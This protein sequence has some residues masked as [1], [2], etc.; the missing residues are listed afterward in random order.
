MHGLGAVT[1]SPSPVAIV[2]N[3]REMLEVN[4]TTNASVLTWSLMYIS[5]N[6]M[7]EQVSDVIITS[8]AM[9]QPTRTINSSVVRFVRRSEL[10][11]TPLISSLLIDSVSLG[12]NGTR[13]T[14]RESFST[15]T[16]GATTMIYIIPGNK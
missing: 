5:E 1:V 2:C 14:C 9:I 11:G 6:G 3:A 12:L 8:T 13:I 10:R 4:C 15:T 16:P 7:V